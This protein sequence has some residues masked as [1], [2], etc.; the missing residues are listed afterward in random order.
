MLMTNFRPLSD[1]RGIQTGVQPDAY[2]AGMA[3]DESASDVGIP[4]VTDACAQRWLEHTGLDRAA[5]EQCLADPEREVLQRP[6][7]W[8]GLTPSPEQRFLVAGGGEAVFVLVASE[9]PGHQYTAITCVIR[10]RSELARQ[11]PPPAH[12]SRLLVPFA[13]AAGVVVLLALVGVGVYALLKKDNETTPTDTT[14]KPA[15]QLVAATFAGQKAPA[16]RGLDVGRAR[17]VHRARGSRPRE[18]CA[19]L[20][21]GSRPAGRWCVEISGGQAVSSWYVPRGRPDRERFRRLCTG[22]AVAQKRC[23]PPASRS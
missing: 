6:P 11:L 2:G 20:R 3:D 7:R 17:V 4:A 9:A 12:R 22:E 10:N 18:V 19:P 1:R 21:R 14:P 16:L 5:L 13:I 23:P 8:S 15:K